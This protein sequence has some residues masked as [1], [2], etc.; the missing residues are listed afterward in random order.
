MRRSRRARRARHAKVS[1]DST[2]QRWS[3]PAEPSDVPPD[4]GREAPPGQGVPG[5]SAP[6]G[7]ADAAV[8]EDPA[9]QE[10]LSADDRVVEQSP[11]LAELTRA[12]GERPDD[13]G[14][15]VAR[16]ALFASRQEWEPALADLRRAVRLAPDAWNA[17]DELGLLYWR[18]GR[19]AEAADCFRRLTAARPTGRGYLF[20]GKSLIQAGDLGGAQSAL[21]RSAEMDP[22]CSETYRLLGGLAD[23]FGHSEEA[24]AYYQRSLEPPSQ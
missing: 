10:L 6:A 11:A 5:A 14:L 22:A 23:R 21:E 19:P 20:L 12:L 17:W 2:G 3:G 8:R 1:Y 15:L 4:D 9:P 7:V 16:G 18:R 13:V 24:S